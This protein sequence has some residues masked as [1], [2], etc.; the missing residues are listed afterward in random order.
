MAGLSNLPPGVSAS[1]IPGNRPEDE[2]YDRAFELLSDARTGF[3]LLAVAEE[4]VA[5]RKCPARWEFG[6]IFCTRP[7]AHPGPHRGAFSGLWFNDAGRRVYGTSA[8]DYL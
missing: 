4:I 7:Y 3:E 6:Q 2:A 8:E 1:D 5:G